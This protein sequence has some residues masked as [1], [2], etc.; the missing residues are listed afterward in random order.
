MEVATAAAKPRR[1]AAPSRAWSW[2]R[3][4]ALNIYLA[5]ALAYMLVPIAV[6]AVFSFV[7]ASENRDRLTF[8]INNGF[9]LDYWSNAFS[10][11]D[12]NQAL[13]PSF[14]L[15]AASTVASTAIGTLMAIGL[16]RHRFLGRGAANLLI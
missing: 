9:T 12:L 4:R 11:P 15:A 5:L 6:I 13:I 7:D 14:G 2:L 16:V 1:V 3:Q 8:A 10:I